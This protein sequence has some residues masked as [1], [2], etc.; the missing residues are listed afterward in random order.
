[1]TPS[2]SVVFQTG[3]RA[4]PPG[5]R[6]QSVLRE[7]SKPAFGRFVSH[8]A[9]HGVGPSGTASGYAE[10]HHRYVVVSPPGATPVAGEA[11]VTGSGQELPP[12]K[13]VASEEAAPRDA[14]AL[15]DHS[16]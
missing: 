12:D 8:E 11:L 13:A 6:P 7:L 1:M 10:L 14:A 3:P 2:R 9:Q 5:T 4:T 16:A 15:R